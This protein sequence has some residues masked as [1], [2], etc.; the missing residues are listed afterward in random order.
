MKDINRK[1][2]IE[3][4]TYEESPL[5]LKHKHKLELPLME[6]V[7]HI[8]VGL[9]LDYTMFTIDISQ[10]FTP[11]GAFL[12]G[13]T[14]LF[15]YHSKSWKIITM[16]AIRETTETV[17]PEKNEFV[18]NTSTQSRSVP[19][20]SDDKQLQGYLLSGK[21]FDAL[22][23]YYSSCDDRGFRRDDSALGKGAKVLCD[24]VTS[25]NFHEL[26]KALKL[27]GYIDDKNNWTNKGFEWL[28]G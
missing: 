9:F 18:V 7:L 19:F 3:L 4:T 1:Q 11:I 12:F 23:A 10:Q 27:E 25:S 8:L 22:S 15:I 14:G 17:V 2:I 26:S 24:G 6:I 28:N 16:T 13:I 5:F 20:V 21:D